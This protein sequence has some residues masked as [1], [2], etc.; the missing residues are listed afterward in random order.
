MR[1]R[2]KASQ[3]RP[4]AKTAWLA[5]TL[6]VSAACSS[7]PIDDPEAAATTA[8]GSAGAGNRTAPKASDR[9]AADRQRSGGSQRSG[10]DQY[11][12]GSEA[13]IT[14]QLLDNSNRLED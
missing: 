1:V 7:A 8:G 14:L 2:S 11:Q 3:A 4:G 9:S 6:A 10:F 5:A 12:R 13:L